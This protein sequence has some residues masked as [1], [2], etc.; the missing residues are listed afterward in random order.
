MQPIPTERSDLRPLCPWSL[1]IDMEEDMRGRGHA[2]TARQAAIQTDAVFANAV[3][4]RISS[5]GS[6]AWPVRGAITSPRPPLPQARPH[7]AGESAQKSLATAPVPDP[8]HHGK[9]MKASPIG[10]VANVV[11]PFRRG[12]SASAKRMGGETR[13]RCGCSVVQ[14]KRQ[15][16]RPPRPAWLRGTS[17]PLAL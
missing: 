1:P 11:V 12:Q 3:A 13:E 6:L 8:M 9:F 16:K 15:R 4:M 2:G 14:R 10:G 5:Q 17:T 7:A